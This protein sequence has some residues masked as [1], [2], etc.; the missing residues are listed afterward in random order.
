[1]KTTEGIGR[2]VHLTCSRLHPAARE[3]RSDRVWSQIP[4]SK[5][6]ERYLAF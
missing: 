4:A 2:A 5:A 3:F 1:M 6:G